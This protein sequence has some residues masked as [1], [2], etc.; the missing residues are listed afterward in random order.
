MTF[1]S[2]KNLLLLLRSFCDS[3]EKQKVYALDDGNSGE[4]LRILRSYWPIFLQ[5]EVIKRDL[6]N[7]NSE[8][9]LWLLNLTT[10]IVNNYKEMMAGEIESE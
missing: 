7:P 1:K 6:A 9:D 4:E 5:S 2:D 3:M 10:R 8:E